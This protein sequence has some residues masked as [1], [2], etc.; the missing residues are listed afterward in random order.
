MTEEKLSSKILADIEASAI[1]GARI[2]G[3]K[4]DLPPMRIV[5][6]VDSWVARAQSKDLSRLD[7]WTEMAL[8]IGSLW[9][10]AMRREFRWE[11]IMAVFPTDAEGKAV[12]VFSPERDFGLF[13]FHEV[14]G[15][16][17]H[18]AQVNILLAFNFVRT[19]RLG[20]KGRK[21]EYLN[22]M[23]HVSRVV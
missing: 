14:L 11:W 19:G 6:A 7:A 10:E 21:D 8:P 15:C 5:E 1:E 23:R 22:V 16:L 13:P 20:G 9:G 2:V 4:M 17:K 18:Q 12:G 3:T